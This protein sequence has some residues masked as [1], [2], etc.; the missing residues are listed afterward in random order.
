[1]IKLTITMMHFNDIDDSDDDYDDNDLK[2]DR[3]DRDLCQPPMRFFF[4]LLLPLP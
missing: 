4:P 3:R 1:M 2:S